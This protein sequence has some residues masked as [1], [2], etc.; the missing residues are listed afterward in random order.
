MTKLL[1]SACNW[2]DS[3]FKTRG[4]TWSGSQ[5]ASTVLRRLCVV[6][7]SAS[8]DSCNTKQ[9]SKVFQSVFHIDHSDIFERFPRFK[10]LYLLRWFNSWTPRYVSVHLKKKKFKYFSL[11]PEISSHFS[12]FKV[13]INCIRKLYFQTK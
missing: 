13:V 11:V 6:S 3:N 2:R 9:T 4:N 10:I 5:G 12:E 8:V 7:R 1:V